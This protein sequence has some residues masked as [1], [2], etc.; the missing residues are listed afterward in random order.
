MSRIFK[1][2]VF[3]AGIMLV[4]I[5]PAAHAQEAAA[6]SIHVPQGDLDLTTSTGRKILEM[7]LDRAVNQVCPANASDREQQACKRAARAS[8]LAQ[9][10]SPL[11]L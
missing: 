2:A 10:K 7:R 9:Q 3:T 4:G 6:Q 8:I 11:P 5:S 1:A